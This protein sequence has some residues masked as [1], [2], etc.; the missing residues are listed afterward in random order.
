MLNQ[1]KVRNR[2]AIHSQDS[3]SVMIIPREDGLVRFYIQISHSIQNVDRNTITWEAILGAA[4]KTF[5][6]YTL[7]I[8]PNDVSW[9]TAY[10][11][12]QRTA[13]E[14]AKF[15]RVFIAGDAC[16]TH[17]PKAGQGM[18]V[19]MMDTYNL[20]WK[21]CSVVKGHSPRSILK[22][23]QSER[24]KVAIDLITFDHKFSRLFSGKPAKDAADE[25][26]ISLDEF[27]H[28]FETGNRFASGT[29]VNYGPSLIVGK[30]NEENQ[31]DGTAVEGPGALSK[32]ELS[33]P[34]AGE[35]RI[36]VGKRLNSAQVVCQSDARPWQLVDWMPSDGRW[37]ILVFCGDIRNGAQLSKVKKLSEYLEHVL[38]PQYT[39]EG[40][41]VDSVIE[42]LTVSKSPRLEVELTDYPRAL[43]PLTT[44]W[45]QPGTGGSGQSKVKSQ[46]YWK[47]FTDDV[48]M[49]PALPLHSLTF[50]SKG[51]LP[52]RPRPRLR[53]VRNRLKRSV[54]CCSPRWLRSLAD[55]A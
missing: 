33:S 19:S 12:G 45:H 48:S 9:W 25:A 23:Y 50:V 55:L 7:D 52:R 2:C 49:P 34:R 4:Q 36:E 22:T 39:P 13:D 31:D 1:V 26:G 54:C 20:T 8:H 29:S 38:V 6:P 3:G 17:S 44:R 47:V 43:R 18:N 37:R 16:H 5:A 28:V 24:R 51:N 15:D 53:K 11:I 10:V 14:F 21:I 40:D 32:P 27:K 30:R 46:D 35:T 42:V 41:D